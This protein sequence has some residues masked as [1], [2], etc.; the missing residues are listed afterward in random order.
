MSIFVNCPIEIVSQAMENLFP[1]KKF[2]CCYGIGEE[3]DDVCGFVQF[4][5]GE[6]PRITINIGLTIIGVVET[7]AHELAHVI[8]GSTCEEEDHHNEEWEATFNLLHSECKRITE[9]TA[10]SN[11]N[12]VLM[13]KADGTTVAGDEVLTTGSQIVLDSPYDI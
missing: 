7:L 5:E 2:Q 4:P 1:E 10:K 8:C 6:V 12:I 13:A 11:G 9:E 3:M